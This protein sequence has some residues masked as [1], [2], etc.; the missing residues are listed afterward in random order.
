MFSRLTR[1]EFIKTASLAALAMS[2]PVEV[3]A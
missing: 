3:F 2:V 1:R